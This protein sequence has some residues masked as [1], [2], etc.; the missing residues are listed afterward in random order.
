M[1]RNLIIALGVLLWTS[2]AVVV[3]FHA[4]AGDWM[5]PVLAIVIVAATTTAWH[6]RRRG[7]VKAS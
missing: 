1:S 6:L 3:F 5:G 2:F 4:L 7:L